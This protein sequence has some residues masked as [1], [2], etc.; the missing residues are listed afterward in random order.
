MKIFK[1][2]F[3]LLM[4]SA[5]VY[6]QNVKIT[7]FDIPVSNARQ[8]FLNGF[9]NWSQSDP[10]SD[11]T[12]PKN[13]QS[14]YR[15]DAT[16]TQFYSSPAYAWNIGLNGAIFGR[17]DDTTRYSYNFDADVSKYFSTSKG[18]FVNGAVNSSYLRQREFGK[19][20]RPVINLFAGLGY[21][22]MVNA[23]A[24][25][26]AIRVDQ[27]LK[28]SGITTGYLPKES[29]LEMARII[30]R[31]S[32]YRDK[33][34]QIYEAKI[35][36]DISDVIEK[37]GKMRGTQMS[38]LAYF[39]IRSV[40]FAGFQGSINYNL[41]NPRFYGGDI[42]LGVGYQ[43]LTRNEVIKSQ[44]PGLELRARYGY[45][46][47]LNHQVF[48]S[49]NA[50]TL[51]DSTFAKVYEGEFAADYWYNMTNQ[52]VFN[53]GYRA[54]LVRQFTQVMTNNQIQLVGDDFSTTNH[55]LFAGFIFYLENYI[56]LQING[57][58][59]RIHDNEERFSTNAT[60]SFIV[61]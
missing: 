3:F 59:D 7:D 5:S 58:Y 35:I 37:S 16:F 22:R 55:R 42:R 11:S 43:V 46:I 36:E 33:Y 51:F 57:A 56:A 60:V 4:V 47:G 45:P 21:G 44:N 13:I 54:N 50:R 34:K 12:L 32:E 53:A 41:T 1:Y 2:C 15:V 6:S 26:K 49:L 28:K 23:T 52:V 30:D 48:F 40:L 17:R 9:Y 39:R 25:A 38:S 24:L 31:E 27:E 20:N 14:D 29:M 19:N 10:L 61:F 8:L 18:F